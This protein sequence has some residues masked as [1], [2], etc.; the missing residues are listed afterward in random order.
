MTREHCRIFISTDSHRHRSVERPRDVNKLTD[1]DVS[2]VWQVLQNIIHCADLSNPTKPLGYYQRWIS[3][4]M[5]EFFEQGDRERELGL[6][7]SPM[8]DRHNITIEKTQ[9]RVDV[10]PQVGFIDYI[11]HPLWETWGD[12]VHPD[13]QPI[14]DALEDNRNY[15]AENFQSPPRSPR[16]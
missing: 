5:D 4:I 2:E 16:R 3:A 7:I 1:I 14:L 15:F 11:V 12:L 8:C 9:C 6:E 10:A 13:V